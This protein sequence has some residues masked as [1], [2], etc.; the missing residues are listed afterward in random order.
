MSTPETNPARANWSDSENDLIVADYFDMLNREIAGE[1]PVKTEHNRALQALTDRTHG[2]IERKHQNISAILQKLGLPWI[3]GYKP[4]KNYQDA[5]VDAIDR[6]LTSAGIPYLVPRRPEHGTAEPKTLYVGPTPP[7][8]REPISEPLAL[9]RL[10]SKFDPAV[11]DARNRK[12]GRSG[13]EL[14]LTFE[15]SRLRAAGRPDLARK[16]DWIS[17]SLGDGA[18]FDILSFSERGEERLLEV[19]TTVG[20]ALTP[21]FISANE[22][23]LSKERPDN[24]RIFRLYDFAREPKAFEIAPPLEEAVYLRTANYR[25]SFH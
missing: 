1:R 23:A 24:F 19:K 5:L 20:H 14:A 12:L 22:C 6:Y 13:E 8:D 7:L 15:Q 3:F 10:I 18:G 11:R 25:A 4:Y 16:V 21:F 9:R 17:E 2:S